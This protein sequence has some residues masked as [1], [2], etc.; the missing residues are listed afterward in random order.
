[1]NKNKWLSEIR[2]SFNMTQEE[3]AD[4][5]KIGRSWYT[6]I[7]NGSNPG[8][9]TAKA[10]A[11]VLGFEWTRFFEHNCDEISQEKSA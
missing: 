2:T 11:S 7:E 1:M 6:K 9:K 4:K 5:A 10:I 8:A 3:V